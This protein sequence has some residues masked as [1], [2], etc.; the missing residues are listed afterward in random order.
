MPTYPFATLQGVS[1]YHPRH[2]TSCRYP[3][4]KPIFLLSNPTPLP[5]TDSSPCRLTVPCL[6]G[7]GVGLPSRS[8]PRIVEPTL[9]TG[10]TRVP[11]KPLRFRPVRPRPSQFNFNCL[12]S[13]SIFV[14]ASS[15]VWIEHS[16][17]RHC[18]IR[19]TVSVTCAEVLSVGLAA[20]GEL[21]DWNATSCAGLLLVERLETARDLPP[22]AKSVEACEL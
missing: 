3:H 10:R 4:P 20:G 1:S 17:D 8:F 5:L 14:W 16:T 11:T 7:V 22:D 15:P 19:P 6:V 21:K 12:L 18:S 9:R 13:S 2:I